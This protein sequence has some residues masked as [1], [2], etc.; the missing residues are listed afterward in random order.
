MLGFCGP[1]P[2]LK[3]Q[4]PLTPAWVAWAV[5]LSPVTFLNPFQPC[6]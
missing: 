4:P 2:V 3:A 6:L 1:A 5:T